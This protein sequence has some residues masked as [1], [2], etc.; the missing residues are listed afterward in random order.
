MLFRARI[1]ASLLWGLLVSS[2]LLLEFPVHCSNFPAVVII[3]FVLKLFARDFFY[4]VLDFISLIF[5]IC[6]HNFQLSLLYLDAF[7]QY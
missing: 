4:F 5:R 1:L 7:E 6:F 2:D 3:P